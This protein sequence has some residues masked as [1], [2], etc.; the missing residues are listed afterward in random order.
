MKRSIYRYKK[1]L[2]LAMAALTFAACT[3]TWDDHYEGT[4]TGAN[5]NQGSLWEAIESRP[6]ELSNFAS[7]IKATGFDR[8]LDGAQVF[9]VFAPTNDNFT[10]AQAQALIAQYEKEKENG[11]RDEDNTVVK[12]FI[13]NHVALYNHSV[14]ADNGDSLIVMMNGKYLAIDTAQIGDAPF[15]TSNNIYSNGVLFTLKKTTTYNPNVF[16]YV[17]KDA[18]LAKVDSFLHNSLHY[19]LNFNEAKSVAGPVKD[20]VTTY[21]DEVY[22]LENDL[23]DYDALDAELN[24]E[25]STYWMLLPTND[26]WDRMVEKYSP[27]FEYYP[28][29]IKNSELTKGTVDSL[30][31]TNT[32]MAI[33]KGT[34]FS[35]T[36]NTDKRMQDSLKAMSTNAVYNYNYRRSY[37]GADSLDYY[38]YKDPF[39]TVFANTTDVECS[40]GKVMKSDKWPIS[41]RETFMQDIIIEAEGG[42][43]VKEVSKYETK[44]GEVK[45]T[46]TP[47]VRTVP[48][49][50]PYYGK[51]SG[52]KFLEL[53]ENTDYLEHYVIFNIRQALS[54]V[55]YD[56]YVVMAPAAAY[57]DSLA[58]PA[59]R[60]PVTVLPT[61]YHRGKDGITIEVMD[62]EEGMLVTQVDSVDVFKI[63]DN[64]QRQPGDYFKFE[65]SAW[66]VSETTPHATLK[67]E[68]FCDQSEV[69][70]GLAQRVMRIDYIL[71]RPRWDLI[72][73]A[74][75]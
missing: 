15:L 66:G 10:E 8:D 25:D 34:A 7:V 23:F 46:C 52:N 18:D 73:S 27:Y 9:T 45:E 59:Q 20:G 26:E 33:L 69:A 70:A 58:S 13:R 56:V 67:L 29:I 54:N 38:A 30:I 61:L 14:A 19:R 32:R 39:N 43:S 44:T 17:G 72:E 50:N 5:M 24:S 62:F 16:E 22:D 21:V 55:P 57:L 35:R 74:A 63:I 53:T 48:S 49:S 6:A 3:D 60:S 65:V 75:Q 71:L 28:G 4:A 51:I 2:G 11:T 40:N 64:D 68:T 12:E 36:V 31:Y 37:W 42:I 1:V 47:T 41:P